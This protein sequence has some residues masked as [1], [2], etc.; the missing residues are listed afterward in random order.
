MSN[1]LK[2]NV[3]IYVCAYPLF[4]Y[5]DPS[6]FFVLCQLWLYHDGTTWTQFV[7]G[8]AAVGYAEGLHL[9]CS[10]DIRIGVFLSPNPKVISSGRNM[11][12]PKWAFHLEHLRWAFCTRDILI[13]SL[14]FADPLATRK[15]PQCIG[16][17]MESDKLWNE[18][19]FARIQAILDFI[20]SLA[21]DWYQF[22]Q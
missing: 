6:S 15:R 10:R 19:V 20:I 21:C 4:F 17:L 22:S 7:A 9:G 13:T 16:G 3:R 5:F 8:P 2:M 12:P 1:I 14:L 11:V 18:M